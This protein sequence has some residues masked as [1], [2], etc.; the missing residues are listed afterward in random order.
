MT[1]SVIIPCYNAERWIAEA[2]E[3][4]LAQTH[5]D[6][7]IIVVDDGST[8][9][10]WKVIRGF[11]EKII[12]ETGPNRGGSH[13]R[14]RGFELSRGEFIQYLDADDYL[15]PEKIAR[16]VAFAVETGAD[17]VYGDWRH[18]H[19]HPDGSVETG[20]VSVSGKQ[21]DVLEALLGLWWVGNLAILF[22]RTIVE[23]TEGWDEDLRAAQDRDFFIQAAMETQ[24]IG[25]LAECD[26][27]YRRYG[28]V[29]VATSSEMRYVLNHKKVTKKA[30]QRLRSEGCLTP[31]YASALAR[32][33]FYLARY[34]FS[35]D[36]RIYA[37]L[38]ERVFSLDPGFQPNENW[39]YNR[40][41]RLFG[42]RGADQLAAWKRKISGAAARS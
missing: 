16:Q 28:N 42:P 32:S 12:A 35:R 10:S 39:L 9:N 21:D 5:P 27:I 2:I 6:V 34:I 31:A 37:E 8:D 33:N 14:N 13:A 7:E 18:Q 19:H 38:I 26:S 1:V 36:R 29:T 17:I 40:C 3:S 4:G 23:R 20:E 15:L 41:F 11:G 24:K 25:Y 30:E 22:R